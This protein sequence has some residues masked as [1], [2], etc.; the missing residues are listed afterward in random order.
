MSELTP[1]N[2][3]SL[4]AMRR[5]AARRGVDV[6]VAVETAG[7]MEGWTSARYS[8]E[9]EPSAYFKVVPDACAC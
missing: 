2:L 6:V 1:C 3:C 5:R 8:D 7:P 9:P 4:N